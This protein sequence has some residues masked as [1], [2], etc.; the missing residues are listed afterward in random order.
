MNDR[1]LEIFAAKIRKDI[2]ELLMHRG[3]GHLGGSLS[4]VEALAVIYGRHMHINPKDPSDPNRDY[5][6]LS[7]GHAGPVLYST[8]A[9]LGYF[10]KSMLMTLNDGG[11]N[12]PSHPDR[13]KTPGV[14][15]TT[16]S[17]GQGTSA[18]AGI[19]TGLKLSGKDNYVYLVV[20]DGE[21]NEGQCWE[22]FQ[23][24]ANYKLDHLIVLIDENKRQLDGFT[25]D[26][27]NPFSIPDKMKAFGFNTQ[28]VKGNDLKAV[29]EAITKAKSVRGEAVCIVLDTIKGAGVKYFEDMVSNHSVKFNN[30]EII[31]AGND[32]IEA[33]NAVIGE[34]LMFELV[35]NRTLK[36]KEMTQVVVDTLASMMDENDK[37]VALDADLGGASK[38]TKLAKSHPDRFIECGIAEANMVGVCAGLSLTGYIPFMHTFG[39]FASRRVYDQV[40]LSCGYAHNTINIY[41]SDPGFCTG[42]NGGTH[43]T[44]EDVALMR[45]LPGSVI[46]DAADAT[47]LEW[48][49]RELA[50]SEGVHYF[51]A[52][53][54]PVRELYKAGSTFTLGKGNV[55]CKGDDVLVISAGQIVNDALDCA[56]ALAKEGISVEVID[57]FT[58]KPL[59][60]DLILS[61]VKGKKAVVTFENH[62]ITGG[63]GSAVAEVLAE[64]GCAIPC[65]RMGVN[66]QFGQVGTQDY[67]QAAFG[68][69]SADLCRCIKEVL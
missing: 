30:D 48:V 12:L 22:A 43:C 38:F 18:A 57:M 1:E 16:G 29:D 50:K 9:E 14:D 55:L 28:Y 53:R 69:T 19:A 26:V 51:R 68:L 64:H 21:L 32:A 35:E 3:Y 2:I 62:S 4:L 65:K 45:A 58:I 52:N 44:L 39:P 56:E 13:L 27:M 40:Y 23:Y 66:E 54:K 67:I 46:V 37:V 7:K 47:Q 33:L 17:L 42:P 31:K 6:V 60:V 61:E 5:F 24:I 41:G 20:G 10:D 34:Q 49:V 63:L 15:M 36:G 59:D 11:T 8:L 25:K